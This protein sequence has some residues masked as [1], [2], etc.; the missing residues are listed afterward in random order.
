MHIAI[1][2]TGQLARMMALAGWRLGF[3]FSFL[4]EPG[5]NPLGVA[6]LGTV[7]ER[8]PELTGEALYNALGKPVSVTVEREHVDV[9]LLKTLQPFC[10]VSPS[11]EAIGISQHRGREKSYMNSIG[12]ST[13]PFKLANSP[14]TLQQA[15]QAIGFP[16]F[17]KSCEEGYDGRGQ[18]KLD[19]EA[20]LTELL[21]T[22]PAEFD[23]VVEGMVHFDTEVSQIAARNKDGECVFYPL[24]ENQHRNGILISSIAPAELSS[25]ELSQKA[26]AIAKHMLNEMDYVGVLSIEFFVVGDQ[27]LVNE[28]APRVHNSGHWTQAAGICCQFENH[29]RSITPLTLGDTRPAAYTGMINLLGESVSSELMKQGNVQLHQYNKSLRPGR[30]VGHI[31]V[32]HIDRQKLKDQLK[33]IRQAIDDNSL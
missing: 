16:A 13:A 23:F 5:E 4:A 33:T 15:V 14:Q 9:E 24:T 27:L 8:T 19:T 22:L 32:W 2:G 20:Q 25:P 17:V 12:I 10:Q 7:V 11:P 30:K 31:N 6:E 28:I 21:D 3:T 29:L 18:W 26:E 1:V